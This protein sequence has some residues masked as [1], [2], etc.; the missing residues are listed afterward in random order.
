MSITAERDGNTLILELQGRL[1]ST[2]SA[3]VEAD[4]L[5]QLDGGAAHVVLDF[6]RLDYISSAGLRVILVTAKRVKQAG[7]IMV[8]C[9]LQPH[10]R[11]VFEI[12]GFLSILTV[13]DDRAA[14]MAKA[15]A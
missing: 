1:D 7:G 4:I 6:A 3:A 10:I 9:A 13:T 5:G 11:E 14:A 2:S 12:S 15:P 8:L